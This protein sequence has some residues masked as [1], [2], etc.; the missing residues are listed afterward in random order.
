MAQGLDSVK[1]MN[2]I[3]FA[4]NEL[5][6][7]LAVDILRRVYHEENGVQAV[8]RRERKRII[9]LAC[10]EVF[11]APGDDDSWQYSAMRKLYRSQEKC[12]F[13]GKNRI[14]SGVVE[15]K[16]AGRTTRTNFTA[17]MSLEESAKVAPEMRAVEVSGAVKKAF[18]GIGEGGS[19]RDKLE[20]KRKMM[21]SWDDF[22]KDN[23]DHLDG[24]ADTKM[25][26]Y[27]KELDESRE[28]KLA[29]GRNHADKRGAGGG[30]K[31]SGSNSDLAADTVD[32]GDEEGGGQKRKKKRRKDG[33]RSP[34]P[35]RLSSFFDD[36]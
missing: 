23:L 10:K 15:D 9:K 7:R 2:K 22:K 13:G 27:R 1:R 28:R 20:A 29:K 8:H 26:Q 16:S 30:A 35:V 31:K 11:D 24:M 18:M 32:S 25:R 17:N 6:Q 3:E 5:A 14:F 21:L 34:S 4:H 33:S 36:D 19:M 12:E